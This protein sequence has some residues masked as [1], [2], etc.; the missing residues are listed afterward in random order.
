M[1]RMG[2]RA[3]SRKATSARGKKLVSKAAAAVVIPSVRKKLR[4]KLASKLIKP[5][6]KET[7]FVA[8][9]KSPASFQ[10]QIPGT[11]KNGARKKVEVPA[12]GISSV[13]VQ[14]RKAEPVAAKTQATKDR[15]AREMSS[16]ESK[17]VPPLPLAPSRQEQ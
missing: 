6:M 1:R 10:K 2:K 3:A 14:S 9:K 8:A 16:H 7:K 11:G 15:P 17:P 4:A 13:P 12:R 5:V